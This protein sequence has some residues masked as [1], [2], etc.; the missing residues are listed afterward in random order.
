M[1]EM[2]LKYLKIKN[3]SGICLKI[4]QRR[5]R[6]IEWEHTCNEMIHEFIIVGAE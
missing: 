6:Y 5:T 1:V 4:I 3:M 2:M